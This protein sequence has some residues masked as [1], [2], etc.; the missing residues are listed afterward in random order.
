MNLWFETYRIYDRV[1]FD[2]GSVVVYVN[3]FEAGLEFSGW[4]LKGNGKYEYCWRG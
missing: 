3:G 2:S 4:E 1:M